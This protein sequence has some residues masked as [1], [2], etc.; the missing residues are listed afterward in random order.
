MR[1]LRIA[2]LRWLLA[3]AWVFAGAAGW[4]RIGDT[5]DQAS[6]RYGEITGRFFDGGRGIMKFRRGELLTEVMFKSNRCS[7][8]TISGPLQRA[9]AEAIVGR[10]G[11]GWQITSLS[12]S[13][14]VWTN[15]TQM[16]SWSQD[17]DGH[18]KLTILAM[19]SD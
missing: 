4:A 18:A 7:S 6:A 1:A 13:G 10:N 2:R 17:A 14:A 16:A 15:Q 9:E 8:V 11:D 12:E 19:M 5:P 3:A